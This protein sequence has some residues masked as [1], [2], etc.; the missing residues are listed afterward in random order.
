MCMD[1]HGAGYTFVFVYSYSMVVQE[2][3]QCL[4]LA[5]LDASVQWMPVE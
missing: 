1:I 5:A 3:T 2:Q 4:R